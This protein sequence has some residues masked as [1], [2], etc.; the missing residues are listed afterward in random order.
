MK[1][2]LLRTTRL[3]GEHCSWHEEAAKSLQPQHPES[4][5]HGSAVQVLVRLQAMEG[6]LTNLNSQR[7]SGAQ[8]LC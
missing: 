7:L 1:A 2:L 3:P 4:I 8:P 6:G 5:L